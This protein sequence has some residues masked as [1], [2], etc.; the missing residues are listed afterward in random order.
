M[1]LRSKIRGSRDCVHLMKPVW[2][3][4]KMFHLDAR[5]TELSVCMYLAAR[6]GQAWSWECFSVSHWP[7]SVAESSQGLGPIPAFCC[8]TGDVGILGSSKRGEAMHMSTM[9]QM[10]IGSPHACTA[11][12]KKGCS[13]STCSQAQPE[14]SIT[15]AC[16]GK[17][18]ELCQKFFIG[19]REKKKLL[20]LA[21]ESVTA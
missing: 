12:Q 9:R 19:R 4:L 20:L 16:K 21:Q 10:L 7:L 14:C 1:A 6:E 15:S 11:W 5:W 8:P 13:P 3:F 18:E 17:L 2:A